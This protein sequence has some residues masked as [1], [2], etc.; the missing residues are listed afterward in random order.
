[1]PNVAF[2]RFLMR[3][4]SRLGEL[5][6]AGAIPGASLAPPVGRLAPPVG[7]LAPPVGH[8]LTNWRR[9]HTS[10]TFRG[11]WRSVHGYDA[12]AKT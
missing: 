9:L 6:G 7:H 4:A 1:M 5:F 3:F 11:V 2:V 8:L 12:R 10:S